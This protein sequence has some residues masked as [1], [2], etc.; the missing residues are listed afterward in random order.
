[1]DLSS[2]G[3]CL[4]KEAVGRNMEREL[5]DGDVVTFTKLIGQV[6]RGGHSAPRC[7]P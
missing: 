7:E 3:T 2:N 5:R 1:M 4:N 6:R